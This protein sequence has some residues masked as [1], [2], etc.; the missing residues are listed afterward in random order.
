MPIDRA[1][2]PTVPPDFPISGQPSAVAGVQ[3]KLGLVQEGGVFYEPGTS[4]SEVQAAFE[5]CKDLVSQMVPY[6]QRKLEQFEGD[7]K[8]TARAV[9]QGLLN[10]NW[11]A[12]EHSK[13]IML[14]TI[15]QLG[16]SVE[17]SDLHP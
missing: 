2:Y 5:L 4:P 11:C 6:C 9:H 13:W 7:Q 1:N 15:E 16:W 12:P 8:R 17:P 14:K 3:P 10:K